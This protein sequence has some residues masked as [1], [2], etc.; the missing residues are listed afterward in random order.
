[1]D[2]DIPSDTATE[3]SL[4][5]GDHDD[6]EP[7]LCDDHRWEMKYCRRPSPRSLGSAT[8]N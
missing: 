5:F 1:M 2:G 7:V 6:D 3:L 4:V 8:L